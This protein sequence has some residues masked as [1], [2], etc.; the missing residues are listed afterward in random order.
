MV[1]SSGYGCPGNASPTADAIGSAWKGID[2]DVFDPCYQ[3]HDPDLAKAAGIYPYF[4][5]LQS[6]EGPVVT[7]D[8][9]PVVMLGS[10]NYLG[11]THHPE[12]L[13]AAH[14][15]IDRY[16]TGCTGSRF[17][18]GNL[19]IHETLEAELAAFVHKPAALVFASGFLANLGVVGLLG[20][21]REAVIF[22]AAEN[23]ASLIDGTLMARCRTVKIFKSVDDLE[24]QLGEADA[25]PHALV[26]TDG[27]FSMT[28]RVVDI[29]RLAALKR[30]Y[31]FRLYLDEAHAIGVLGPQGRGSAAEVGVLDDVDVIFGTFSKALASLGGFVAADG[32]VIEYLRHRART[33]IFSA[34]LPPPATAAALAALRV[35]Q[36]D[37][38]LFTRL[39]ENVE[40]FRVGVERLGFNTM[41]SRTPIVPVFVGSESLA[42]TMCREAL[43]LGLFV[44]PAVHPA[45]PFGHALIR[46]SVTPAHTK[47][48]LQTAL[49]VI[50]SLAA[51]YRIP[52]V[53][54]ATVP[55]ARG[56]DFE[57]FLGA[58]VQR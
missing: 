28:G 47:A 33:Q 19:D 49:D 55:S 43:G 7:V 9:R 51:K 50:E 2:V 5:A 37:E 35:M 11:L 16:G 12:V 41:G 48:H 36:K 20:H 58:K 42:F 34:A 18:N 6:S 29:A 17:L 15:A 54:P 30:R 31:H 26:V 13:K 32:P 52:R 23:H 40:F 25:W 24:R 22:A 57:K 3:Y 10:N 56:L 1:Q 44:T 53:D 39:W 38:S 27:V 4:Q 14:D 21:P 45:V 46:T 8:G